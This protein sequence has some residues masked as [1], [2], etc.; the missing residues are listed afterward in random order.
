VAVAWRNGIARAILG[1]WSVENLILARSA[2][3]IDLT[4]VA[5]SGFE[6]G[7]NTNIRPDIISGKSVYL[8]GSGYPGGKALNPAAFA[9]PPSDP[10]TGIP[11]RQGTL[12]R[13]F[14]RGFGATEWDL[15]VHRDFVLRDR[16][17][18]QWRAEMFN[19]LN[20]PNFGAPNTDFG[21]SGFGISTEMLSQSLS[22]GS[23][24]GGG[25]H[26]LYQIGGPRSIQLALKLSF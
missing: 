26:S 20:H 22:N 3:P 25:F 19:V 5:F 1:G 6:S 23:L 17:R 12:A 8:F 13:N 4:D 10:S 14:L 7:V 15:A 2:P 18:L 24:G 9:D 21:A 11:L 16:L